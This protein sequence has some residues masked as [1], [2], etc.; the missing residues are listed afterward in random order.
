MTIGDGFERRND[1]LLDSRLGRTPRHYFGV[2]GQPLMLVP[3]DIRKCTVFI[4]RK[5]MLSGRSEAESLLPDGTGFFV[6][7]PIPE[8]AA[9]AGVVYVVTAKHV[10]EKS[11]TRSLDNHIYIR[12]NSVNGPPAIIATDPGDW[13]THPTDASVDVAV[14]TVGAIDS[15]VYDY[16]H[17]STNM[18]ATKEIIEKNGIGVGD[19]IFLTGLFVNHYGQKRSLPI[20]RVG[21]IALMPEEPI[22]SGNKLMDAYLVEAR[23]IGGLSGSPV[24]VHLIGPRPGGATSLGGQIYWLGLMH[25]HWDGRL[26]DA[27]AVRG[28]PEAVNMGIAIVIPVEKILEVLNQDLFVKQR[29]ESIAG[30]RSKHAPTPD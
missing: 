24:F 6:S 21:N 19:E 11:P 28:D 25:G 13:V 18:A 12:V 30:Y 16:K 29:E 10:I 7:V 9:G 26:S 4:C 5:Y 15:N 3:D 2:K 23:S 20:V 22:T 17:F 14:L 1:L 8:I 27:D